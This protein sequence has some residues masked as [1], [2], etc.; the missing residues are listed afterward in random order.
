MIKA[1][2]QPSIAGVCDFPFA[3]ASA[4]ASSATTTW[5][6]FI[7]RV[8]FST[9]LFDSHFP[10]RS[11]VCVVS[12]FSRS[13]AVAKPIRIS[14]TIGELDDALKTMEGYG[15]FLRGFHAAT[16]DVEDEPERDAEKPIV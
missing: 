3:L 7:H 12:S 16:G 4:P 14:L 5:L 6:C 11:A 13:Q 1:P 10:R 2:T 9:V 8:T 15:M